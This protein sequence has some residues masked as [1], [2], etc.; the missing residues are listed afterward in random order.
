M[1][2]FVHKATIQMVSFYIHQSIR[3]LVPLIK[4]STVDSRAFPVAG[5]KTVDFLLRL[6]CSKFDTV[7]LF[8]VYAMI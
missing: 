8:K 3:Y 5:R 1:V 6:I 7:Q 4:R 2:L